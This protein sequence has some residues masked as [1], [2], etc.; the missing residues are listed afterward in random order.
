MSTDSTFFKPTPKHQ[1]QLAKDEAKED[2]KRA[3]IFLII[4]VV[5]CV[6]VSNFVP[7][8]NII[9]Y[10]FYLLSTW[11]HEMG[12]SITAMFFGSWYNPVTV[13]FSGAGLTRHMV[14]GN[15]G[16]AF[17]AAGGLLGT[18][19]V[20]GILIL[21]GKTAKRAK[22]GLSILS[23]IMLVSCVVLMLIPTII[24]FSLETMVGGLSIAVMGVG[25]FF[26]ARKA[27]PK[28]QQFIIQFIGAS[29]GLFTISRREY[30][31]ID[32][33]P[34]SY[35]TAISDVGHISDALFL[36][37]WFW[38]GLIF[39]LS[40]IIM[41]ASLYFAFRTKKKKKKGADPTSGSSTYTSGI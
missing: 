8:G 31:F 25:I 10:P 20:G 19:I 9:L 27:K 32:E 6:G 23:V 30:L 41:G 38:G 21:F 35:P 29:A 17:V 26:I 7:Y 14:Q 39:G 2:R 37:Y 34:G 13:D 1:P 11:F 4:S 18:P 36:P 28:V 5:V 22:I 16:R 40:I 24:S 3:L 15:I 12:H 33:I